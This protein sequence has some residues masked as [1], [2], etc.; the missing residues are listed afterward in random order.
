MVLLKGVMK[1]HSA[2]ENGLAN[3]VESTDL[4]MPLVREGRSCHP[5]DLL[6]QVLGTSGPPDIAELQFTPAQASIANSQ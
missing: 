4:Y 3:T 5:I 6:N 2:L 1:N